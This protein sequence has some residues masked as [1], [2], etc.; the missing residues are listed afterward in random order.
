MSRDVVL[1]QVAGR[2]VTVGDLIGLFES[3]DPDRVIGELDGE[4]VTVA[5]GLRRLQ[6][7][8]L[9]PPLVPEEDRLPGE[10]WAEAVVVR[11]EAPY[12]RCPF[13]GTAKGVA[14]CLNLCEM[15]AGLASEFNAGLLAVLAERR[16][17]IVVLE[18]LGGC[19]CGPANLLGYAVARDYHDYRCPMNPANRPDPLAHL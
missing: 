18:A 17:R 7:T 16:R 9:L 2:D 4:T 6:R 10:E 11:G 19:T 1:G 8:A 3:M 13:C 14:G 12:G 15:P 5:E